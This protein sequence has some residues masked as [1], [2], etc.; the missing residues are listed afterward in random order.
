MPCPGAVSGVQGSRQAG[1]RL[2][3]I[4]P[5]L[6]GSSSMERLTASQPCKASLNMEGLTSRAPCAGE[7]K[8]E[9]GGAPKDAG[10]VW[11]GWGAACPRAGAGAGEERLRLGHGQVA[12]PAA[13]EHSTRGAGSGKAVWTGERRSQRQVQKKIGRGLRPASGWRSC[14]SKTGE[15]G[16]SWRPCWLHAAGHK[17]GW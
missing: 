2:E 12:L 4:A 15:I 1:I 3:A 13:T 14:T 8:G 5:P 9:G 6:Q 11:R 10:Q 16:W 17:P 7:H